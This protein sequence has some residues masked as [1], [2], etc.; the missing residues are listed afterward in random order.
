MPKL[1]KTFCD[2]AALPSG[3]TKSGEPK[4]K[5]LYWDSSLP[6]FG[7]SV[8]A[9]G[10]R[11]FVAQGRLH[12]KALRY[13]IG[14]HGDERWPVDDARKMAKKVIQMME[15]GIDPRVEQGKS[16]AAGVTLRET[17]EDYLANHKTGHSK[18]LRA[19]TQTD[20]RRHVE[21]NLADIADEPIAGIT[22]KQCLERFNDLTAR[23]LTGQ[24]NQ[25]MVTLRALCNYARTMHRTPN[26]KPT[27]LADNPVTLAFG[28]GNE[29]KL[30]KAK[31]RHARVPPDKIGAV[32]A[33]LQK[34][35]AEARTVDDRTSADYVCMLLLTGL[36]AG[37][38][39]RMLW[40]NVNLEQ[41]W[42]RIP[43]DD[44]KNHNAITLPMSEAL[45]SILK[46]RK[47]ASAAPEHVA[48]R[49]A[50]Q[51]A[52]EDSPYVFASWGKKSPHLTEAKGT[53]LHV[54][55]VA[56]LHLTPHDLRRTFEDVAGACMISGD[57]RRILL[58]HMS[59]DVH[60]R[61]YA[62][63]QDPKALARAVNAIGQWYM[64]QAEAAQAQ[65]EP[66]AEA[67]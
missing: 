45:R 40:S 49:R 50:N 64:T 67:A 66:V 27:I 8:T 15:N 24:A 16:A 36:R 4:L 38:C 5:A 47:D 14:R 52:R 34:R 42:F 62:N 57:Q 29:G 17:M 28:K 59:G 32:W 30:H 9:N 60:A 13:K 54:S 55:A 6:G 25:C 56:G 18:P 37:E 43:E 10:A 23:G 3:L 44:A 48:R 22:W 61:H 35:R 2:T 51:E 63:S 65:A 7:L 53:M 26:G 20:I 41:G 58:N 46:A 33:M 11:T 1:T 21:Q 39:Q 12:G 19:S 31:T